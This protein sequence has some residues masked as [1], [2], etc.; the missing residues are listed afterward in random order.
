S[1]QISAL[2]ALRR[3]NIVHRDIKPANILI[4]FQG[5]AVLSDFGLSAITDADGTRDYHSWKYNE[6]VGTIGYMAPEMCHPDVDR[7]GYS[8]AVDV[9][10]LGVVFLQ[11]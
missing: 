6:V 3:H 8:P 2:D 9:W 11:I 10:S 7:R 4:D 5:R 1:E